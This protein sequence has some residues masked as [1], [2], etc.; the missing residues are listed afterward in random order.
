MDVGQRKRLR[1]AF[2]L[3]TLPGNVNLRSARGLGDNAAVPP[4]PDERTRRR[5]QRRLLQWYRRHRRDLP[6]RSTADPYHILVSEIMLQ[7]TQVARVIPKYHE[8]LARYPTLEVLSRARLREVRRAW[9]PLG[10]YHRSVHLH[11]IARETMAR[12]GGRLP[13]AG[14]AL[15]A[16]R[17]IG[18]YTAGAV[19]SFAYGQDAA[20]VDTNVRRVL[21]RIVWGERRRRR[22]RGERAIWTLAEA[23]LPPGRA[24]DWNQ[25]LMDFGA[26]W[27]TARAPRCQPCPMRRFCASYPLTPTPAPHRTQPRTHGIRPSREGPATSPAVNGPEAG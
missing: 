3:G 4:L 8:F 17:G 24:Y 26:T 21:G 13:D 6:W 1:H 23:V 12:Y 5:F 18:R 9:Y 16:M 10:Y 27:C 19:L 14:E 20:V 11:G 15:R 2:I 7:Q 25:A 22:V